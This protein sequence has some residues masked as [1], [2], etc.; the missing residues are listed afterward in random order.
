MHTK[1]GIAAGVRQAITDQAGYTHAEITDEKDL[2]TDIGL[3]TLDRVELV[4]N[5]E[6]FFGISIS[7]DESNGVRTVGDMVRTVESKLAEKGQVAA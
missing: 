6:E 3:D 7:E 4:M 1:Q 2:Q 5:I